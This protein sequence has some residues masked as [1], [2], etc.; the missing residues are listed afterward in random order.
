MSQ[1]IEVDEISMM[2]WKE[3]SLTYLKEVILNMWRKKG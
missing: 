3:M 1:K 2:F